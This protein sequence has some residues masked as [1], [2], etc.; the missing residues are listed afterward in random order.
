[1]QVQDKSASISV[2]AAAL[3]STRT[4]GANLDMTVVARS[5]SQAA[6]RA[7]LTQCVITAV[8][9]VPLFGLADVPLFQG[10]DNPLWLYL[11]FLLQLPGSLLFIPIF[12][13]THR[14][15]V[16]EMSSFW[17]ACWCVVLV[18][19]VALTIFFRKPWRYRMY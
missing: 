12:S 9:L 16:S 15:G 1:M 19:G 8:M 6:R 18:Q 13:L 17:V 5:W 14:L 4:L 10:A 3:R 11:A 2:S 7:A